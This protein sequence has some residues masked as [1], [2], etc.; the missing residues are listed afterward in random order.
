LPLVA[1]LE[2]LRG[3]RR[4]VFEADLAGGAAGVD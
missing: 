4:G 2:T 1:V 3:V